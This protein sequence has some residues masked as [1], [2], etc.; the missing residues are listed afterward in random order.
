[1]VNDSAMVKSTRITPKDLKACGLKSHKQC[2]EHIC[3]TSISLMKP[4]RFAT[5]KSKQYTKLK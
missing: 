4:T 5:L 1:M 2:I 3:S